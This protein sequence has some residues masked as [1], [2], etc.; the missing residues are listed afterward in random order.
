MVT[1]VAAGAA[2]TLR[3]VIVGGCTSTVNCTPLLAS[4]PTVTTTLPLTA[5]VGTGTTMLAA[6][7]LLGVAVVP[8]NVTLLV[9]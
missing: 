8:L 5:P 4:P 1:G 7:Q 9:P 6:F 2:V 3:L